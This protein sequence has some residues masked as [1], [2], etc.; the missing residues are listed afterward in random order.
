[1]LRRQRKPMDQSASGIEIGILKRLYANSAAAVALPIL[2]L[3]RFAT[4]QIEA[5]INH[6]AGLQ[7][8]GL[9]ARGTADSLPG[10][11]T[12]LSAQTSSRCSS[13]AHRNVTV[14]VQGILKAPVSSTV[15][16]IF[17]ARCPCG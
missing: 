1:M 11:H 9:S 14:A 16:W 8:S 4:R 3:S 5:I 6:H 10:N 15:R 2:R 17:A 12:R 13:R 7:K